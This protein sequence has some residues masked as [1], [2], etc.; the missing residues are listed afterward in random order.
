MPD[1]DTD[2][3]MDDEDKGIPGLVQKTSETAQNSPALVFI[4]LLY[5]C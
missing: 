2:T 5:R 4:R 3:N 1:T